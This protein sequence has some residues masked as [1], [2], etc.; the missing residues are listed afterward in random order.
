FAAARGGDF[1]TGAIAAG[2]AEGVTAVAADGM[3]KYL[4]ARFVT[5]EQFRVA[6]AQ[7]V[8]IAAGSLV[9][10]DPNDAAWVAGN[11]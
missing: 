2:A 9:N 8:G 3:G 11:V 4:N 10:G 6:T 7:I 1:K 5:D